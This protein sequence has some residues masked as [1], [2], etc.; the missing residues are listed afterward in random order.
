MSK[1]HL[2]NSKKGPKKINPKKNNLPKTRGVSLNRFEIIRP[3]GIKRQEN[4][5]YYIKKGALWKKQSSSEKLTKVMDL[6]DILETEK[7]FY[8]MDE[9]GN[10][11]RGKNYG[12][13]GQG[14]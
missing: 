14:K 7:Y 12:I 4:F 2:V 13:K 8:A 5:S 10:L 6:D 9:K 11:I 3:L 1:V